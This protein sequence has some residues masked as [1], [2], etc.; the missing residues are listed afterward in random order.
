MMEK[1]L[2]QW[3]ARAVIKRLDK[4]RGSGRILDIG[5]GNYPYFLNQVAFTQKYAVDKAVPAD[6]QGIDFRLLDLAD[7]PVL[8]YTDGFFD[9]I[10]A[11]AVLEHFS[12][13]VAL[14]VLAEAYRCLVPGGKFVATVPAGRADK[15]LKLMN[16][17]GLVSGEEVGEHQQ[18]YSRPLVRRQLLAAGFA[19]PDISI[20]YFELGFNIIAQAQKQQ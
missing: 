9:I 13:P 3:R 20:N 2:S 14:K 5:C 18:S 12:P 19:G 1:Y 8:P 17:L 6:C 16:G 15:V 10:T 4:T 11:L 7:R